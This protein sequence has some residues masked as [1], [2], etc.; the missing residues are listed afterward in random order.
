MDTHLHSGDWDLQQPDSRAQRT[1]QQ[2]WE[3]GKATAP[4]EAGH[5]SSRCR[6]RVKKSGL[7]REQDT[8]LTQHR[9]HGLL[10]RE[11]QKQATPI[12]IIVNT[13]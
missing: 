13:Y 7:V 10:S 4:A 6:G 11:E 1:K 5:V 8:Q 12:I 9:E 3:R 2:L